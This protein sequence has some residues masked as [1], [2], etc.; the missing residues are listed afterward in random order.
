LA[1]QFTL[2]NDLVHFQLPDRQQADRSLCDRDTSKNALRAK[3]EIAY[4]A[5]ID[6]EVDSALGI[7]L[8]SEACAAGEADG[9]YWLGLSYDKGFGVEKNESKA[10]AMLQKACDIGDVFTCKSTR[11]HMKLMDE[12]Q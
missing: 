4:L 5:G 10:R 11:S 7:G 9:C 8:L 1:I 3:R 2:W 6:I 12:R